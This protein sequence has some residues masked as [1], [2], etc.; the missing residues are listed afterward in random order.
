MTGR[1][2]LLLIFGG[3]SAEHEISLA[4]AAGVAGAA[5][6][7]KNQILF[8]HI[9]T[10]G[11]WSL[12]ER[13][14]DPPD[15]GVPVTLPPALG[16]PALLEVG[17]GNRHPFDVAFPLI[18]GP[19]GEDGTIQ[20]L[21]E[22][23]GVPYVGSGVAASAIGMDKSLAKTV[24]RA[25]GV[26]VVDHVLLRWEQHERDSGGVAKRLSQAGLSPPLFVK[27]ASLGSSIGIARV[28]EEG[29]L[30]PALSGAFRFDEKV[31]IER[32]ASAREI[33][34]AILGNTV[35]SKPPAASRL[36]EIRPRGGWYDYQRKYNSGMTDILIPADL[37]KKAEQE[38][39][40]LSL[41]A[42]GAIG[43][44]GM[45]RVDFF[46]DEKKGGIYVNEINTVP[47]FTATSVYPRL[48]EAAGLS[49]GALI[50]RL[51]ALALERH[52][53]RG[54]YVAPANRPSR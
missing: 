44:D 39:Q 49:Y 11:A 32:A 51:I 15:K 50:D 14:E 48:W 52:Q 53:A 36:A 40:R 20:G 24:F 28:E 47:G 3:R 4:S 7:A 38:I 42:F 10:D 33:E 34:C 1:R 19:F 16:G 17:S 22:F 9:G 46:V 29:E 18:H 27:P 54:R 30:L 5:D 31:L 23:L 21:L 45:A 35:G 12:L 43:G 2:R 25:A 8:L 26:P 6:P 13:P 37:P 41:L